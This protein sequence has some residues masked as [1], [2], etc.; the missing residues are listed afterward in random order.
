MEFGRFARPTFRFRRGRSTV[1]QNEQLASPL[2]R[3]AFQV[4][5]L[6]LEKAAELKPQQKK[7]RQK[8]LAGFEPAP[9]KGTDFE[10]V[11]LTTPSQRQHLEIGGIDPPTCRMRIDRSTT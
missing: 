8:T 3:E 7:E 1:L 10:S 2:F 6:V 5:M 4:E 9:P 11:T